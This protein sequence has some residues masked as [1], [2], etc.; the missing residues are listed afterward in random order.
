MSSAGRF[1]T[2]DISPESFQH[3]PD[4]VAQVRQKLWIDREASR[5]VLQTKK[6]RIHGK[7]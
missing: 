7:P 3:H 4:E 1:L 2:F 5:G 6:K